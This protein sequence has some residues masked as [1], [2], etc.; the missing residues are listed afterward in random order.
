MQVLPAHPKVDILVTAAQSNPLLVVEVKRR[1]F[2]GAAR[3]QVSLYSRAVGADFVM[4]VDPWQILTAPTQGGS[5]DWERAVALPTAS[6][7]RHYTEVS[8]V[9]KIEG[10]YLESLIESWL[11]DFSF[12][13][14]HERPPGYDELE[15]IGLASR[16]H[17]SETHAQAKL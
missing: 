15:R 2:D 11:R 13:W 12:S 9:D 17:D 16:L 1:K 5:P 7:L 14:K 10:F 4:A 8:E 6:I 3:D